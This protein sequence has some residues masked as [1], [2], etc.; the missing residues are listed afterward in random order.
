MVKNR[1]NRLLQNWWKPVLLGL[2]SG[3]AKAV[4]YLLF[5]HC[6]G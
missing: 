5:I 3:A 1:V 4:G 2:V 6:L